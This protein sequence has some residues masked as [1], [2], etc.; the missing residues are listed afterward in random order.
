VRLPPVVR[1]S[2]AVRFGVLVFGLVLFAVAIVL[3]LE[4]KLGLSPWDVL[5]QGIAKHTPLTFGTASIT[6]A[7]AVLILG[8]LLRAPIGIGT[9]A[10]AVLVGGVIE[11]LTRIDA[12]DRL[13]DSSLGTRIILLAVAIALIGISSALYLGADLGAGPRDSLMVVGAQ[14][15]RYRVGV[16]RGA[17]ELTALAAGFALGGTVGIGTVAFALLVGPAVEAGFWLLERTPLA[18]PAIPRARPAES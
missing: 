17:L 10:N 18:V 15:T 1:G 14:R 11:G 7:F 9:A 3:Q 6:V 5:H 8:W 4:S 12:V 2:F 13:S 16:V